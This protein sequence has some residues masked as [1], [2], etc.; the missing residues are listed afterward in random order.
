MSEQL[1][2]YKSLIIHDYICEF[3][4]MICESIRILFAYI[5]IAI[6]VLLVFN[7]QSVNQCISVSKLR[8]TLM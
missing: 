1:E 4:Q 8:Y 5:S 2:K 7:V 6:R 3:L